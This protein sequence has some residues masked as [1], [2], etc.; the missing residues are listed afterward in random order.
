MAVLYVQAQAF[1]LAGSGV[2]IGDTS[3]VL[4]SMKDIDGNNLTMANFGTK[5]YCTI[6][7]GNG[8]FEEAITFSGITQ[9][10]NGTA[11]LTGVNT[12]LFLSPYTETAGLAKT[13]AGGTQL[14]VTNSAAFY[15]NFANA[16]N[17]LTIT[18]PWT[19][20]VTTG[21]P[22]L[23]A[24]VD[25]AVAEE[26]VGF[27][28]LSRQAI[29]GAA[30]ASTTVKGLVELATQAEL[31]ARST[32]GGSGALLVPT[33][34][35][36]RSLLM[37]DYVVDTGA[38][39]AYVITTVP[40]TTAYVAGQIFTF[41]AANAS[42]GT[43]TLNVN[44]LG[45]KTILK[46]TNTPLA[47]NDIV[48]GSIV[49]VQYDG[50][51]MQLLS[52]TANTYATQRQVQDGFL[53]YAADT[54]AANAYVITLSPVPPAYA[55]G[56]FFTFKAANTNTTA[57]TINVN[58]L[59]VKDIRKNGTT[60]L[61]AGDILAGKMVTIAYDGTNFQLITAPNNLEAG[62][63]TPIT[64]NHAHKRRAVVMSPARDLADAS[65]T[66][67]YAHNLGVTPNWVRIHAIFGQGSAAPAAMS[68]GTYD[69]TNTSTILLTGAGADGVTTANI[70]SI[71]DS[72]GSNT[73]S[74]TVT[75]TS[76]DVVLV[77]T[78]TGLG[79]GTIQA[80]IETGV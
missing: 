64:T 28:Q 44:G 1:T 27:G 77:W 2:I 5:G 65:G 78:K 21:R 55:A 12:V 37:S 22:R 79:S 73:Q 49:M 32:T 11:T 42:T 58:S 19:F 68:Y 61:E 31:D 69:G 47:A 29:A 43:S 6:E 80:I 17:P 8:E 18:A 30:N 50:T 41:K 59:G 39:D 74:A 34:D 16:S 54:G 38:A 76:T 62:I 60:A 40:V 46:Q 57:S 4:T 70:V 56:Q 48:A 75:V 23:S 10:A 53:T 3:I 24:D 9:N 26:L 72:G 52:G 36:M 20:D 66:V 45:A 71:T 14:I 35:I 33:P 15:S 67:N 13:H 25:T 63:G 7:P 51:S